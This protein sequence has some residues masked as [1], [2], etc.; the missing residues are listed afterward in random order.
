L[1]I[2]PAALIHPTRLALTGTTKGP[3]LFELMELLGRQEC[4]KRLERA[5]NFIAKG[6]KNA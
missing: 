4:M 5:I 2:K 1:E 6:D 3:S